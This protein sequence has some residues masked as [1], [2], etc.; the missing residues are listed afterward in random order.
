MIKKRTRPQLNVRD[1]SLDPSD[2]APTD[3]LQQQS[4]NEQGEAN[5]PYV[6]FPLTIIL[7]FLPNVYPSATVSLSS[8]NFASFAAHGEA[9]MHPN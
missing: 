4:E 9:S 7:V 3:A 1:R 8:S 6:S 5:L 2:S